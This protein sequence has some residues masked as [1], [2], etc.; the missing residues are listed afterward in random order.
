ML[1]VRRRLGTRAPESD[2][3]ALYRELWPRAVS[4]ARRIVNDSAV[5]EELA[6]EAFTRAFERWSSVARHPSPTA[7]VLRVTL[8]L[9]ISET[10]RKRLPPPAESHANHDDRVVLGV[11]VRDGLAKLSDKQRQAIV[12]RY[13][14]GCEETEIA[15]AMG[16]STGTV[17]THLTRGRQHLAALIGGNADELLAPDPSP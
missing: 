3:D 17:K 1:A 16:I 9:A 12:L 4:S 6:Q 5:A 14:G 11:I 10:R 7:W 15:G 2:F 8:N 13:I